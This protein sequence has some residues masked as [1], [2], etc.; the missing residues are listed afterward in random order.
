M[1]EIVALLSSKK[2][3]S[4]R[5]ER[6]LQNVSDDRVRVVGTSVEFTPQTTILSN[7]ILC[8]RCSFQKI[9]SSR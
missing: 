6:I 4:L 2:L 7:G 8:K 3:N 1:I 5:R 9:D